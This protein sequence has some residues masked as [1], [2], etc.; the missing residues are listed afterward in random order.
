MQK[1]IDIRNSIVLLGCLW[2]AFHFLQ[3]IRDR[4]LWG[5]LLLSLSPLSGLHPSII[6]QFSRVCL[7]TLPA[8]T[9]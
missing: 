6:E 3:L 1:H 9:G 8:H 4:V 2:L 7:L 5:S